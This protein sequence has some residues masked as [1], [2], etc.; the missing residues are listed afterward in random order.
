MAPLSASAK[1]RLERIAAGVP[2]AMV[3]LTGRSRGGAAALRAHLAY[4]TRQGR[5]PA[6]T[7]DGERLAGQDRLEALLED[8]L[9]ANAAQARGADGPAATQS[10]AFILSMPPGTPPEPVEAAARAWARAV[11]AGRHD[12]LMVRHDDTGH[13]HVHLTVRAVGRDGRRLGPGPGDLQ[14]WRERFAAELRRYGI[15]AEAT[16]RLARGQIRKPSPLPARKAEQRGITPHAA[17]AIRQAAEAEAAGPEAPEPPAWSRALQERHQA[18]RQ[19]YLSHAEALERGDAAD[20]RL[21]CDLRRFVADLPI[22]LTRHQVLAVELRMVRARLSPPH[23]A[24]PAPPP[25]GPAD[26]RLR[27]SP[28]VPLPDP[29]LPRPR[30]RG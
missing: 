11:F 1:A 21:A 12:W 18:I 28:A 10:V 4:I 2:E 23:P 6:E 27:D 29:R 22:P 26:V 25:G 17:E 14:Q 5:L 9:L 24:M 8:W 7:Q 20:R 30:G 15:A 19:A 13:P 3:K 16:P